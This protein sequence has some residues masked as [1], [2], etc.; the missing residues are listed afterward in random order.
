MKILV[1]VVTA[2][3]GAMLGGCSYYD[4]AYADYDDDGSNY[5]YVPPLPAYRPPPSWTQMPSSRSSC[6]TGRNFC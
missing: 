2:C 5:V 1:I 6:G 4:D 3:V